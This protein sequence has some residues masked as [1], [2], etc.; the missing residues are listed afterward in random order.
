MKIILQ[1]VVYGPQVP[2]SEEIRVPSAKEIRVPSVEETNVPAFETKLQEKKRPSGQNFIP[3]QV[4]LA[5]SVRVP[6]KR[7]FPTSTI[8]KKIVFN[9]PS[10]N[11]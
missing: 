7:K 3:R 5:N 11:K 4:Q 9:K 2:S 1:I 8:T 10:S 6:A